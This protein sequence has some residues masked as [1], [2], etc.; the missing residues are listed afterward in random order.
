MLID[1]RVV[2]TCLL[3]YNNLKGYHMNI[4]VVGCGYWGKQHVR[5]LH[6]LGHLHS[7]CDTDS[8]S[9][10]SMISKYNVP[11]F[12]WQAVLNNKEI[13]AIIIATPAPLH[14]NMAKEAL[15]A[16][17]HVLVEKPI[18]FTKS[19][20][21][22]LVKISTEKN[23]QLMAG[24]I[25]LYHP[26]FIKM[27]SLINTGVI[28]ELNYIS[29]TRVNMANIR[30]EDDVLWAFGPH[31]VALVLALAGNEVIDLK[32]HG[33]YNISTSHKNTSYIQM[34]FK[35]NIQADI[36]LSWTYPY[37]KQ[38]LIAVGTEGAIVFN[39]IPSWEEKIKIYKDG[40]QWRR[41][42]E[43]NYKQEE[44]IKIDQSEPLSCELNYFIDSITNK[45]KQKNEFIEVTE[46]LENAYLKRYQT[47]GKKVDMHAQTNDLSV[48]NELCFSDTVRLGN[49]LDIESGVNIGEYTAIGNEVNLKKNVSIGH[50][51]IL[52]DG[53]QVGD[54]TKISNYAT[55]CKNVVLQESVT[56][57]S[58]VIFTESS[59]PICIRSKQI[60]IVESGVKIC[61][62][63][64]IQSG[65]KIGKGAIIDIRAVVRED[66]KPFSFM[67]GNP[68]VIA[69]WVSKSGTIMDIE[70]LFCPQERKRYKIDDS[71][72]LSSVEA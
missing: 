56:I 44:A 4:T 37:K 66:V 41:G 21:L 7:I 2:L 10:S 42:L 55:I 5:V 22:Q 57:D 15:K 68:A 32:G 45:K 26:A 20:V 24:H 69:G 53:V 12:S 61:A 9:I 60:T 23:C 70:N 48:V 49:E 11:G 65:I 1:K 47:L 14:F 54:G 36:L 64:I 29:S 13:D 3:S 50:H 8:L 58:H 16:G 38:E 30:R 59:T 46:V 28:G 72:F 6:E 31:D 18:S 33:G 71:G 51:A 43:W 17:K 27:K 39:D 34:F 40:S 62:A 52:E 35:K 63:A 19:D 67:R 25:I